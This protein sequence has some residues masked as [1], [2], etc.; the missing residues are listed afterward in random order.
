MGFTKIVWN[1]STTDLKNS[2]LFWNLIGLLNSLW[3]W[4]GPKPQF[5]YENRVISVCFLY[6]GTGWSPKNPHKQSAILR[7][8]MRWKRQMHLFF[9]HCSDSRTCTATVTDYFEPAFFLH[10]TYRGCCSRCLQ[11]T[12]IELLIRCSD[13][14][15]RTATGRHFFYCRLA[16]S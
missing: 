1:P 10:K 9:H 11:C 2:N 12:S 4:A 7:L 3:S 14:C 16:A 8:I 15:A 6:L 13:M 5:L